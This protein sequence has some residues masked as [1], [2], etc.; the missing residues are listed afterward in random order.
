MYVDDEPSLRQ[1]IPLP[2]RADG[3]EVTTV[4]EGK[5]VLEL[6]QENP[7]KYDLILSD[8]SLLDI[9]GIEMGKQIRKNLQTAN[10]PIVFLS[11]DISKRLE[12]IEQL[13]GITLGL[14]KPTSN[15]ELVAAINQTLNRVREPT[16]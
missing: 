6:L 11:G 10:I 16:A 4:S 5:E 8:I 9:D 3:F 1:F 7:D 2:L 13:G 14:K 15:K 12:E